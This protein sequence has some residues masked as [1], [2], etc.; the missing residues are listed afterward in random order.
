[1]GW[2]EVFFPETQHVQ[3]CTIARRLHLNQKIDAQVSM[4]VYVTCIRGF[5]DEHGV[6]SHDVGARETL[7]IF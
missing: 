2:R 7:N 5:V 3:L 1:M 4:C 6:H